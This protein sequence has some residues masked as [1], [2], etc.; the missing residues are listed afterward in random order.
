MMCLIVLGEKGWA[1]ACVCERG[2]ECERISAGVR[3]EQE[4]GV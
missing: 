3:F 2:F 4:Y 1:S